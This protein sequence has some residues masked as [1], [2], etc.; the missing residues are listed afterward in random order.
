MIG[1]GIVGNPFLIKE[2][3]N[4]LN[5]KRNY[6]VTYKQRIKQC[7]NHASKLVDL[8]GEK[9]AIRE[10]RGLA[11]HYINGLYNAARYKEKMNKINTYSDLVDILDDYRKQ[12]V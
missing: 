5:G 3:N 6:K 4:Y 7:I 8:K 12:L 1:R 11:P 10:M 2:I 9:V